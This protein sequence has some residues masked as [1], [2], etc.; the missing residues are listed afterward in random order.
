MWLLWVQREAADLLLR[1]WVD[2]GFVG[3]VG[4]D[5]GVVAAKGAVQGGE[6]EDCWVSG[7]AVNSREGLVVG[8]VGWGVDFDC[9]GFLEIES[10]YRAVVAGCV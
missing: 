6:V 3:G 1:E 10:A 5:A 2:V 9:D 7:Y 8:R 4:F